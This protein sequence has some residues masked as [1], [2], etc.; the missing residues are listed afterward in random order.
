MRP[1]DTRN[2]WAALDRQSQGPK[3]KNEKGGQRKMVELEGVQDWMEVGK[4]PWSWGGRG[5]C[6]VGGCWVQVRGDG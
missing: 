3:E 1:F 2:A 4:I 6:G 5:A